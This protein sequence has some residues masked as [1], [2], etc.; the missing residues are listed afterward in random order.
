MSASRIFHANL[1][2]GRLRVTRLQHALSFVVFAHVVDEAA[3]TG[4][5]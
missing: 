4:A 2:E 1:A 5:M 3:P